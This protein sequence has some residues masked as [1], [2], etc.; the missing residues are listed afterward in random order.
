MPALQ[1]NDVLLCAKNRER[2]VML[3]WR[4]LKPT[5]LKGEDQ[6]EEDSPGER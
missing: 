3:R 1:K 2:G 6:A 5:L 4:R